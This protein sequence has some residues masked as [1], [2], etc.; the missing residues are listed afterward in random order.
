MWA[1][2]DHCVDGGNDDCNSSHNGDGDNDDD[3]TSVARA[4]REFYC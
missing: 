1:V 4:E 3:W 2:V